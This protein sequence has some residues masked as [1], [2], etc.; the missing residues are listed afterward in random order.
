MRSNRY[1]GLV[2][3][4]VMLVAS[5][6]PALAQTSGGMSPDP[7]TEEESLAQDARAYAADTGVSLQE[8]V[9]RLELQDSAGGLNAAL[10]AN[11]RDTFAG[12]WIQHDPEFRII[13][14][15]TGDD[16]IE[17]VR[18]YVEGGPLADI[19]EV[20][21]AL[22]TLAE[23]E[24][25]QAKAVSAV[26]DLGVPVEAGTNVIENRV[27]LYVTDRAPIDSA[28][29]GGSLLLPDY[30]VVNQVKALSV[31][32]ISI[33]AGRNI[34]C[35]SGFSVQ[36][37]YTGTKGTTT[38]AHCDSP[39]YYIGVY[40]PMEHE[41]E[42]GSFDVQ[43]HTTP[44]YTPEPWIWDGSSFRSVTAMKR[45]Q[46]QMVNQYVC[47]HGKATGFTC[48][49]IVKTNFQPSGAG[50]GCV[51]N[52]TFVWVHHSSGQRLSDGGDSGGPWFIG[53][54]AYGIHKGHNPGGVENDAYYMAVDFIESGLPVNVLLD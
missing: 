25:A 53:Y 5:A 11:E 27:E 2:A 44:G 23:L 14:Q 8:A 10:T 26:R 21:T 41:V 29:Q 30:V 51:F 42:G 40:L 13:V 28:V 19:V 46:D 6:V 54:T 18:P 1:F 31:N 22:V 7:L 33:E 37:V 24:A 39:Q 9:R 45:W 48:G 34:G 17:R 47:K 35:T 4:L 43:W 50:C 3:M 20:R 52:A 49:Y 16:G 36:N 38:A 15:F 12:A 32:D